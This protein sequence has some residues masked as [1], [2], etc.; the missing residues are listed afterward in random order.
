ML[1]KG[2]VADLGASLRGDL[3]RASDPAY[4]ASRAIWNRNIDKHPALIARCIGAA[5]VRNCVDFAREHSLLVSV[6]GGGHNFSGTAVAE[7][8]LVI[9]LSDMN[10]V[11]VDPVRRTA[12]AEGGTKWGQFDRETQA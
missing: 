6:R 9:D 3:I 4:E 11:R 12:Q 10:A 8:G 7:H 5:D 2:S 1:S